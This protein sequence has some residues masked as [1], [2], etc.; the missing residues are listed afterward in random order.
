MRLRMIHLVGL[1][2]LAILAVSAGCG[3]AEPDLE[4]VSAEELLLISAERLASLEAFAF[5]LVHENGYTQIVRGLAMERA[6]GEVAGPER[7]QAELRAR[8]GPINVNLRLIILPEGSWITNPLTGQWES[9]DISIAQFF[10]PAT[11]V[12]A[13]MTE[14]SNVEVTGSEVISGAATRR[15]EGTVDS[16]ALETLLPGVARGQPLTVRLWIGVDDPV[17]HRLEV[18]GA[19]E[20]GDSPDLV[21]R[22]TLSDFGSE[23]QIQA[24]Q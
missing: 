4:A 13:L 15:I 2:G 11:G 23:F 22:L 6:E 18:I 10:D 19:V 3:E 1:L 17:V 9:E 12:A 21:R 24:P 14:L 20:P 7:M 8:A 16:G 5:T